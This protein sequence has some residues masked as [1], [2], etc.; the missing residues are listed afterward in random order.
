M[1]ASASDPT[2]NLIERSAE[3]TEAVRTGS[4]IGLD[5]RSGARATLACRGEPVARVIAPTTRGTSK[6][7]DVQAEI[8]YNNF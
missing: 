8:L 1:R 2:L 6:R 4:A 5:T 7:N 3:N